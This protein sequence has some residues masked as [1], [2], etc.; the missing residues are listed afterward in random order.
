MP[1][2]P[3]THKPRPIFADHILFVCAFSSLLNP[4]GRFESF[5]FTQRQWMPTH[6][7][8]LGNNYSTPFCS[9]MPSETL[10]DWRG[11]PHD[12]V[13]LR[14]RGPDHRLGFGATGEPV[15]CEIPLARAMIRPRLRD[16]RASNCND[17]SSEKTHMMASLSPSASRECSALNFK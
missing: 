15:Q 12:R 5:C 4:Y 10:S 7:A 13:Q 2:A 6:G 8:I 9:A 14:P 3:S 1:A 16:S 17:G 11:A